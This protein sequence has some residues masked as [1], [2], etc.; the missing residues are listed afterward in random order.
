MKVQNIARAEPNSILLIGHLANI[1]GGFSME[2]YLP[3]GN[4]MISLP[5]IN[6]ET[7]GIEDF[8]YLSMQ[9][10]GLIEVRGG[11]TVPLMKPFLSEN[12]SELPLT[13]LQWTREHYWI[14]S[15]TAKAGNHDFT[16]T[17][18]TPVGERG[19]AMKLSVTVAETTELTWGLNGCWDSSWH[20][21][22]MDKPLDGKT[23]CYYS[24]WNRN[25]IFDF[26][27]GAP[28]FAFAAMTSK[29]T[30]QEQTQTENSISYKITRTDT[31]ETGHSCELIFY[32]GLGYEEVSAA[33]SAQEIYRRGWNW[34]YNRTAK[35][36]DERSRQMSTPKLTEL[37]NTNLFFCLFYATGITVD[38]EE[39]V[40]A[41]SRGTRYYVSAAY[42]D[43]D[44]LL[45]A[46]PSILDADH[47]LAEQV[48]HY[49]FG[50]QRRNIGIHSHYIDGTVL[51]PGFELDELMAPIVALE[52]YV[53]QTGDKEILKDT[54]VQKG[55]TQILKQ[56][57]TVRHPEIALYETFLQPTD[58][59]IVY[60][61]L[62]YDNMLVW[63]CM[64]ALAK[65]YPE[66]YAS[67]T[68]VA[69]DI[70]AA[71]YEHC[72]FY[73]KDNKPYF[74]WSM[75]LNGHHNIYDEPPGS[76]Q[77]LPYYG[78]C[79]RTDEIWCNTVSIIRSPAYEYSF[80][81]YPIA[82]IG[83]AHAPYPWI[84]SLC[85]SLLSGHAEQAIKEV[86]LLEMDNGIACESVDPVKGTCTTGAAFATCAGFLCHSLKVANDELTM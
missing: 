84:L 15:M 39:L 38:T 24:G 54:N 46:Y 12:G 47:A 31:I 70:K 78:F 80:A 44:V 74:G 52:A 65:L 26:R 43:R 33:T 86:E 56:L 53:D 41:T 48:L 58:D 67:L 30:K 77:L 85:N 66:K 76:L 8:T 25:L 71:I 59:E 28:V 50:R 9:H 18:L 57:E 45:W 29:D 4:E 27:C 79:E 37:Y 35:W 42:W 22:N 17:I 72:V 20:C 23:F 69:E 63:R 62:T 82:E 55:I 19:F 13:N 10:K 40:C 68:K 73:D 16:M 75:D 21:I 60:P 34:E 49:I 36:L 5:K 7:A 64:N 83:C 61:Y 1:Q 81:N 32:W 6:E 51:E 14:P 3:T 2:Y 11:E